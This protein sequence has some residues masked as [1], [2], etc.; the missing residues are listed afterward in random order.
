MPLIG[1]YLAVA[2]AVLLKGPVGAVLPFVVA[3]VYLLSEGR[4]PLPWHGRRWFDLAHEFGLWWG[5]PLVVGL[6]APWF[7]WA[8]SQTHGQLAEV[9]FWHHNLARAWGGSVVL[10]AHPWWF[11][12]PQ[13][14]LDFLPWSPLLLL[15]VWSCLRHGWWR[16]DPDA[17]FGLVWLLTVLVLLSC[18]QFKRSDYLLPAYPGA[19]LFLGC[20]A[21][22]WYLAARQ[23]RRLAVAFSVVLAG[24]VA[25]WCVFLYVVLPNREPAWQS[26]T[27]AA[28]VRCLA[29]PPQRVLFFRTEAH[30][31][32]F[33]MGRPLE[34]LVEW[35]DL[36]AR[37]ARS[38]T[39]YVVLPASCLKEG[40]PSLGPVRLQEV[41]RSS[42]QI[43]GGH[44]Q[45]LVVLRACPLDELALTD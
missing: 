24:C 9:F 20:V 35:E 4:L 25:A 26:R 29:P 34:I 27:F 41:L 21:E 33:H 17:R 43:V 10:K 28:S 6:A 1:A 40:M 44:G 38:D 36:R 8:N 19:A 30:P 14:L 12:G 31:L 39:A 7:V 18:S 2:A 22:R 23:P 11:Y 37:L 42:S 32:A 16:Q 45:P 13:L 15:A 5:V 3:G